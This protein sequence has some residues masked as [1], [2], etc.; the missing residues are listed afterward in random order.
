MKAYLPPLTY[1]MEPSSTFR[2]ATFDISEWVPTAADDYDQMTLVPPSPTI[3]PRWSTR[4][5]PQPRR[6][7]SFAPSLRDQWPHLTFLFTYEGGLTILGLPGGVRFRNATASGCTAPS[8]ATGPFMTRIWPSWILVILQRGF[9]QKHVENQDSR[10]PLDENRADGFLCG[11]STARAGNDD[12]AAA[13]QSR[14]RPPAY[15]DCGRS[16]MP[17]DPNQGRTEGDVAIKAQPDFHLRH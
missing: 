15:E 10:A 14:R 7:E 17:E 12:R 4:S 6:C 8:L 1:L 11:R 2:P 9:G 13:V 5:S 16:H 3:S